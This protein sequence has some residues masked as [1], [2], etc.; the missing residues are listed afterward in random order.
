MSHSSIK[1][2]L[3]S[4]ILWVVISM[5]GKKGDEVDCGKA[6]VVKGYGYTNEEVCACPSIYGAKDKCTLKCDGGD[7][8]ER[9]K[10]LIL[11][12]SPLNSD[13]FRVR[14]G[15]GEKV[16]ED[17]TIKG[18]GAWDL[19]VSCDGS[20]ASQ[21]C[22][23]AYIDCY[24][25]D[26]CEI[27]CGGGKQACEGLFIQ[28]SNA[29]GD[30]ELTCDGSGYAEE[31]CKDVKIECGGY[32]KGYAKPYAKDPVCKITCRGTKNACDG[33]TVTKDPF[34]EC[35]CFAE[36]GGFCPKDIC[37]PQNGGGNGG[38]YDGGNGGGNNGGNGGGYN[39]GGNNGG[40]GGG[41]G[42]NDKGKEEGR[43]RGSRSRS[44]SSSKSDS[45]SDSKSQS[46]K[47]RGSGGKRDANG[48]NG[49]GDAYKNGGQN[50]GYNGETGGK[51]GGNGGGY[52][53]Y[54]ANGGQTGGYNGENGGKNG[55]ENNG[56]GGYKNGGGNGGDGGYK[57]G[58]AGQNGGQTGGNG[59]K[60]A[61]KNGGNGGYNGGK[62][63]NNGGYKGGNGGG[64]G[65]DYGNNGG[66]V[67]MKRDYKDY[68]YGDK[69]GKSYR[70]DGYERRERG[71]KT[72]KGSDSKSGSKSGSGSKSRSSRG[73]GSGSNRD[74]KRDAKDYGNRG[75]GGYRNDPTDKG[76]PVYKRQSAL[77]NDENV[78]FGEGEDINDINDNHNDHITLSLGK[79]STINLWAIIVLFA[80]LN[81]AL[82]VC[83]NRNKKM[84]YNKQQLQE[85]EH[86]IYAEE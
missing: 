50:G 59:G 2:I 12:G 37:V 9:C 1:L 84:S 31:P 26:D 47:G 21:V 57:G 83:Y 41:K 55:G 10:G 66:N 75:D 48:G 68:G 74:G 34:G 8:G 58:N 30:V 56:N 11:K 81:V 61:Y 22:A 36:K 79:T 72:S 65:G 71:G 69:D 6:P 32:S 78:I 16:C 43:G 73:R 23:N 44:R 17:A 3:L 62:G 27:K 14:C 5:N 49:G 25:K 77:N 33:V 13:D 7:G 70:S 64:N 39:G 86:E 19:K 85:Q 24:V 45:G 35:R 82:Y 63:G 42:D 28:G 20:K 54:K 53:D 80:I 15:G 29:P 51:N 46:G 4:S 60:N 76:Y 38:G 67:D 40:N 52:G 18:N